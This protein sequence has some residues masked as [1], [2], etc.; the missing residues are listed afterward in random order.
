M[1]LENDEFNEIQGFIKSGGNIY[2]EFKKETYLFARETLI[3]RACREKK[4]KIV[5]ILLDVYES[6]YKIAEKFVCNEND[7]DL[8]LK[9]IF[10]ASSEEEIKK[11][12]N[13]KLQE[14]SKKSLVFLADRKQCVLVPVVDDKDLMLKLYKNGLL[15]INSR[16][17]DGANPG[18]MVGIMNRLDLLKRM[19]A[20]GLNFKESLPS[21]CDIKH[22]FNL[23]EI[24]LQESK[25][26]G[27]IKYC[28]N[29]LELTHK[30]LLQFTLKNKSF[31]VFEFVLEYVCRQNGLSDKKSFVQK[32]YENNIVFFWNCSD[33]GNNE[34]LAHIFTV[35]NIRL[36]TFFRD[37]LKDSKSV[38][39]IK[40]IIEIE[41]EN[42][43]DLLD[44]KDLD[45]NRTI[46]DEIWLDIFTHNENILKQINK[47]IVKLIIFTFKSTNRNFQA[48]A[49]NFFNSIDPIAIY[50]EANENTA[51]F[52]ALELDCPPLIVHLISK[53]TNLLHKNKEGHTTLSAACKYSNLEIVK[54]IL[55]A[56]PSLINE[57]TANEYYP[58]AELNY[59]KDSFLNI[60]KELLKRGANLHVHD[61]KYY[62]VLHHAVLSQNFNLVKLCLN[63]GMD[64]TTKGIDDNT[65]LHLSANQENLEI[66]NLLLDTG[67]IDIETKNY[68]GNTILHI[69]CN[70]LNPQLFFSFVEKTK[71]NV[72]SLND[73][74]QSAI[75]CCYDNERFQRLLE[76]GADT[77]I[78][79]Q[80]NVP[81]YITVAYDH[82]I[83]I[84]KEI[85]SNSHIDLTVTSI[86]NETL[87]QLMPTIPMS[88]SEYIHNE[89][90]KEM[91]RKCTNTLDNS[92]CSA[93]D[94][95]SRSGNLQILKYMFKYAEP[96]LEKRNWAGNT[97]IFGNL[98]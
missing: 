62:T 56:E 43:D 28:L 19:I 59:K 94:Y 79:G 7:K 57:M 47:N 38:Y 83:D 67:K 53:G 64:P 15:T 80:H 37:F 84:L 11:V 65:V 70:S 39:Y 71:P 55:N 52:I 46:L 51:L 89:N 14:N 81:F 26:I 49:K 88:I 86:Y 44:S 78:V 97:A 50:D 27:L 34:L 18:H 20:I 3:S 17:R 30:D 82:K 85:F 29:E 72:N 74:G 76:M 9:Y 54:F 40:E 95:A 6:D 98:K 48:Q 41:R 87:L 32:Y 42:L 10:I 2:K 61:Y 68:R 91:F 66:F 69:V 5:E 23:I 22:S 60:F 93:F 75:Y 96:D 63:L 13:L 92:N 21:C 35:Y 77:S 24:V 33:S 31:E 90:L 36:K 25:C 12:L 8:L 4:T 16:T 45:T 1:S 58:L 73:S